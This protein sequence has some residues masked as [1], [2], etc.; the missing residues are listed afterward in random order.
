MTTPRAARP[1]RRLPDRQP[2]RALTAIGYYLATT[3]AV[4]LTLTNITDSP[5]ALLLSI[6]TSVLLLVPLVVLAP[7]QPAPDREKEPDP[8]PVLQRR[9]P[10]APRHAGTKATGGAE[11]GPAVPATTPEGPP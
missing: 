2:A 8:R 7:R 6:G 9:T 1:A 3:A 4:A 10:V 11:A 5:V